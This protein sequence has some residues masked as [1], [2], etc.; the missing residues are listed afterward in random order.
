M[1]R[2]GGSATGQGWSAG[3]LG[4]QVVG[5]L[6]LA[7]VVLVGAARSEAKEPAGGGRTVEGALKAHVERLAGPA[8]K[9]RGAWEDRVQAAAYVAAELE[10]AGLKPLPGRKDYFVDFG[11]TPGKPEGRNVCAWWPEPPKQAKEAGEYVLL[12]AHY[13]HLGVKDGVV[14]PGADDNASGVAVLIEAVRA[15]IGRESLVLRT[16]A[17]PRAL[18]V[19]AFDLEEQ[20]LIGSRRF[21]AEPPVPLEKC[22][23]F[24][25]MDQMGRSI[26]DLAPGTLFLMGS[27]WCPWLDG[28][29]AQAPV[30]EGIAKA[31]IGMD[32]QPPTGY[33]DYVPFQEKSIPFLFISTGA[34]GHY[35]QPGD[36]PDLLDYARM[37]KHV[38]FVRDLT[39]A[40]LAVEVRPAWDATGPQPRLDEIQVIRD[41][42]GKAV[43]KLA[44]MGIEGPIR[45]A[46]TNFQT[47]LD[48]IIARGAV[49]AAERTN[50]RNTAR[51]LFQQAVALL[52]A[53]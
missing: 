30:A 43:P 19:V 33:S 21:V 34:C 47:Y 51:V 48:K 37:E 53:K 46:V 3:G 9:G 31:R 26:A 5:A 23:L 10:A 13:D 25:T 29:L 32:F 7:C 4:G 36:T 6:A 27:E 49:T 11:G 44:E 20:G 40:A 52:N 50:V 39:L 38:G 45:F 2:Q 41:L 22:A 8:L 18:C 17:L 42:V 12:T 1:Q 14:Y 35:H 24:L 28:Y 16:S 15:L